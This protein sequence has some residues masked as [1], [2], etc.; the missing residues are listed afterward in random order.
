M[1]V[2]LMMGLPGA[3]KSTLAKKWFPN[4]V[5]IN[6]DLLGSRDA[7]LN[8]MK[9]ALNSNKDVIIDRTNINKKQ[10][11]YWI[12]LALGYGAESIVGIYLEVAEEECVARVLDRK[13]HATIKENTPLEDIRGIVYKFSRDFE[14]PSLTEGFSSIILTK[15]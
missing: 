11:A 3:G 4:H 8:A 9:T 12:D 1:K 2:I 14:F 6:Q 15:N 13:N 7:C 10:R 5:Y